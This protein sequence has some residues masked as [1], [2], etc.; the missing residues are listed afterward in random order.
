MT[1]AQ[2][3]FLVRNADTQ[4]LSEAFVMLS[5]GSSVLEVRRF[6]E[7]LFSSEE[8]LAI[9]DCLSTRLR[10]AHKFWRSKEWLFSREPAEQ[11]SD[12]R[13][14]R[15]R[16]EHLRGG[17]REL[18]ELGCGLGGDT[19]FLSQHFQVS[20][21]ERCPARAELCRF[22]LSRLGFPGSLVENREVKCEDLEGDTLY[23]DPARR[24]GVRL[25]RPEE[26]LPPLSQVDRCF[27]EGRFQRVGI[28]CAPGLTELPEGPWELTFLSIEGHLKEAFLLLGHQHAQKKR[29]VLFGKENEQPLVYEPLGRAIPSCQPSPGLYLH[30]PDPAILRADA[31]DS[32]AHLTHSGVVHPKIGYLVGPDPIRDGS[33]DSFQILDTFP[34]NWKI[35][36]KKIASSGWSEYEYLARGV[37]FSQPEVRAKLAFKRPKNSTALRGSVILFRE[38]QGYRVVLAQRL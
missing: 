12:S 22:N 36:K 19:V 35:L 1:P 24:D 13:I 23:V 21:W 2:A 8:C 26:W 6:L 38:D 11:A 27:R 20:A 30:N 25:N 5:E 17:S 28:K 4:P 10:F 9:L 3:K 33:A 34:L 14:A 16:A 15:W 37:P 31:L 18:T 29:A 7:R 32:L